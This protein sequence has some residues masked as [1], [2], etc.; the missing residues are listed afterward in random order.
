MAEAKKLPSGSWRVLLYT[1]TDDAGKKKYKSF[2]GPTKKE[3]EFLAAEHNFKNGG[4][5]NNR[6]SLGQ[7]FDLYLESK[8]SLLSPST[9]RSYITIRNNYLKRLMRKDINAITQADVQRAINLEASRLSPKTVRNITG[10][11]V[12]VLE[13]Y[14]PNFKAK[15]TLPQKVKKLL[16]IPSEK[17]MAQLYIKAKGQKVELPLLLASQLGLRASEI[18]G[19]TYDCIDREEKTVTIK[20]ARV[21]G[22]EGNV[23]KE[24]KS[25]AGNRTIPCPEHILEMI[26]EGADGELILKVTSNAITKQWTRFIRK[27][28]EEYFNFHS[29][30]HYFCSKALLIGIPRK[31]VAELMGHATENMINYVY[32]HTFKDKKEEFAKQ[33]ISHFE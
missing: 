19:L 33:L 24:P 26:G 27:S 20:Q 30:R 22:N 6:M 7:A 21:Y 11:L 8:S 17:E 14:R 31:Y 1:G 32:G 10:L 13:M 23:L 15:I 9:M 16:Y 18:A 29:L 28:G 5:I 2:T 25:Y 4:T 3:A 12:P